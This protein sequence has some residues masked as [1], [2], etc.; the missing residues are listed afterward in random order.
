M[1][2]MSKLAGWEPEYELPLIAACHLILSSVAVLARAGIPTGSTTQYLP[3][4]LCTTCT[5]LQPEQTQVQ[6]GGKC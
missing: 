5:P 1:C 3:M 6:S 2:G 4:C